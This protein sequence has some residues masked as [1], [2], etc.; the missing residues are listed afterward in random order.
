MTAPFT[1]RTRFASPSGMTLRVFR[2]LS[3]FGSV[4]FLTVLCNLVRNKLLSLWVGPVGVGLMSILS[5]ALEMLSTVSSLGIRQSAVKEIAS[6]LADP[7][8]PRHVS[9]VTLWL[10]LAGA[11]LTLILAWPLSIATWGDASHTPLFIFLAIAVAASVLTQGNRAVMQG[12][13]ALSTLARASIWGV[14]GGLLVS[15]PLYFFFGINGVLPSVIAVSLIVAI[16]S[17]IGARRSLP[18]LSPA[19]RS[20]RPATLPLLRLGFWLTLSAAA[21][22][23]SSYA[24]TVVINRIADTATV[25][26][27]QAGHTLVDRYGGIIFT[28]IAMEF[29]PRLVANIHSPRRTRLIVNHEISLILAILIPALPLFL[30]LLPVILPLLFSDSFLPALPYA[31]WALPGMIFRAASWCLAYIIIA[32]GDG[33][34]YLSVELASSLLFVILSVLGFHIDGL[35]GL[36]IAYSLWYL[37]YLIITAA[38]SRFHYHIGFS[39]RAIFLL[40]L[41]FS[42]WA[43][44]LCV[45]YLL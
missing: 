19:P 40:P 38:I 5:S 12:L 30:I 24:V 42:A 20:T 6:P 37:A 29:Y 41:A 43:L 22:L 10:A 15:V 34:L 28:A 8:T 11:L 21:A 27:F 23:V 17:R 31:V 16:A 44:T 26:L 14:A 33:R 1:P 36:G 32:R 9:R 35:R 4:E 18:P 25:G 3:I 13:G 2:A 45:V 39:T 7:Y